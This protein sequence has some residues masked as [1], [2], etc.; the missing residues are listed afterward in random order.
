[1]IRSW[2]VDV[3]PMVSA[4]NASMNLNKTAA[5][6]F[7]A[8]FVLVGLLGFVGPLAPKGALLGVFAVSPLHNIVHLAGGIVLLAAA[9][10][11]GGANSRVTLLIF[12][13][14]YGL[15]TIL[16]LIAGATLT[17]LG[18]AINSADNVLHL[19]LTI[20]LLGVP[21]AVK[22]GSGSAAGGAR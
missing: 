12:G 3:H 20:A 16:G 22:Q 9:L 6:V 15:V 5:I 14:V 7:G 4:M 1:M 17:S 19:V 18:V 11:G 10:T 8:V 2:L 21:L 13:A